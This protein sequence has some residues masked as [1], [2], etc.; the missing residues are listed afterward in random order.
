RRVGV[1]RGIRHRIMAPVRLNHA[2]VQRVDAAIRLAGG[3]P[4][5]LRTRDA[6][7]A[8]GDKGYPDERAHDPTR[9]VWPFRPVVLNA[10]TRTLPRNGIGPR[11]SGLCT[12]GSL[13]SVV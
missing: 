6:C 3:R 11:T 2:R 9:A 13:P 4:G 8:Q 7:G 12:V 1:Q 5:R 10:A